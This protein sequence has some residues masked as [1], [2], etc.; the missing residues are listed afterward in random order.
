[1]KNRLLLPL[2]LIVLAGVVVL[3]Y[4]F[5]LHK[6][7]NINL[8]LSPAAATA[9]LDGKSTIKPGEFYA[10]PG[11]HT[12]VANFN[13]FSSTTVNF[14]A[15]KTGIKK[16]YV[17]LEPNSQAGYD[18]LTSHPED[19]K[20]REGFGGQNF[21]SQSGDLLKNNPIIQYL[22]FIGPGDAAFKIDYSFPKS[23]SS[24][25]TVIVT[26][27]TDAGKTYALN[28]LQGKGYPVDSPNLL[29]VNAEAA[30][31]SSGY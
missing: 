21:S 7:N 5:S 20:T 26:Y 12:I 19:Q 24:Q 3:I 1:M 27:Y 4:I 13:G 16:V 10:A 9:K 29:F 17:I 15:D 28:W 31:N 23:G 18:W 14:T 25:V 6:P 30:Y 22:P 2:L 8:I 11:S